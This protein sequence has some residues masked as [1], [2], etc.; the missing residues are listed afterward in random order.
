MKSLTVPFSTVQAAAPLFLSPTSPVLSLVI[1]SI[2]TLAPKSALSADLTYLEAPKQS[3]SAIYKSIRLAEKRISISYYEAQPCDT[4]TKVLVR[5]IQERKKER[6]S[7]KAR[8][9]FDA[10]PIREEEV[11][12]F[13]EHLRRNGIESRIFNNSYKWNPRYNHR[14]HAKY[15]VADQRL[16][17][18]GRNLTDNYF[19]MKAQEVNWID[20]DVLIEETR[21]SQ[22]AQKHFEMIWDNNHTYTPDR[23]SQSL[24]NQAQS[25]CLKWG[26]REQALLDFLKTGHQQFLNE[27]K[28]SQCS[29]VKFVADDMEF[30][31]VAFDWDAQT[32]IGGGFEKLNR[33]RIDKKP[34]VKALVRLLAPA[35]KLTLV[36][37]IYIPFGKVGEILDQKR[38]AGI[39]IALYTNHYRGSGYIFE[40]VHNYYTRRDSRGSQRNY[41]IGTAA[42]SDLDWE[43]S[44][45]N[46]RYSNHAKLYIVN[47][48]DVAVTSQNF[49]PRSY[50][51]NVESGA[52]ISNCPEFA[53]HIETSYARRMTS[54][55]SA[56]EQEGVQRRLRGQYDAPVT[57]PDERWMA[58][59]IEQFL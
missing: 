8:F 21:A 44:V 2:L 38:Q 20:G 18:G 1:A 7:L 31:T 16:I 50:M 59:F 40:D 22:D 48:R 13:P 33:E 54:G 41:S 23:P 39:P 12:F 34:T 5:A 10:H 37:H 57:E 43:F 52:Y 49:D 26:A 51:H 35:E 19:G 53:R 32:Q 9:I 14:N 15:I 30:S 28:S 29:Q 55:L 3:L 25:S 17:T 45:P 6:P 36:N 11:L 42:H 4:V 24:M 47:G 58:W 46:V 27:S 56:Q